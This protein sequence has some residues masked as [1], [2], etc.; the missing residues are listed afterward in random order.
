M[1]D[2]KKQCEEQTKLA[3]EDQRLIYKGKILKDGDVLSALGVTDGHTM[4][5]VK[6]PGAKKDTPAPVRNTRRRD[7][8]SNSPVLSARESLKD[9]LVLISRHLNKD[10]A[11]HEKLM[12]LGL[13]GCF[14]KCRGRLGREGAL[15]SSDGGGGASASC[16]R[17]IS[18]GE[19]C[20]SATHFCTKDLAVLLAEWVDGHLLQ[21]SQQRLDAIL[22]ENGVRTETPS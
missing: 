6:G 10:F 21:R 1:L 7:C 18:H 17:C 9:E 22:H 19:D 14:G 4:H 2:V 20:A 13:A 12:A 5:L 8:V 3:P 16:P 15:G 11:P